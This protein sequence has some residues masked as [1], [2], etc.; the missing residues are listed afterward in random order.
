[1]A[2]SLSF[3]SFMVAAALA[4]CGGETPPPAQAPA[5]AS[6]PPEAKNSTP[7]PTAAPAPAPVAAPEPPKPTAPS[8]VVKYTGLAHPE[9]V[10]Y[11]P[12]GDRYLVSN[13][14]ASAFAKDNNGFISVLSPDG[15]VTNLKRIEGGKSKVTLDAPKGM[16]I[17]KGVLYAADLTVVRM[18]D[19]KTGAPKGE[20][21]IAGSTFLN[22]LAS[23]PDGK[24]YAS[25][26]GAKM[27]ATA[28]MEPTGTDA[29]YVVEK[30]H[31]KAIAK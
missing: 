18:F 12:D 6:T 28:N 7:Q 8:P 9:S 26:T 30:G 14:N 20:V 3:A 27:G 1:M 5:A 23:A 24:V 13:I 17:D 4:S 10:L 31:A 16:A 11:D 22:D 19:L 15:Q 21:A 29:V 2:R 25:D